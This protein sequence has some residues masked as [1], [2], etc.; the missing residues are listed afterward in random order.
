MTQLSKEEIKKIVDQNYIEDVN[1]RSQKP[2][3]TGQS[4]VN[5]TL[6][7]HAYSAA[8]ATAY[9]D[10]YWSSYNTTYYKTEYNGT[11]CVDCA[12]FVSQAIYA[13]EGKNPPDT[14]GMGTGGNYYTDWYY[15]FNNP[16]GTQNGSGS[17]PWINVQGQMSFIRNNASQVGPYGVLTTFT[18]VT[19]GDPVYISQDST[20]DHEG[21]IITKGSSLSTTTIDAH[22]T[23]RHHYALSN[24]ATFTPE[25][26]HIQGWQN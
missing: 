6:T 7:T 15:V 25:Y 22:C 12:N 10:T 5:L 26:V 20:R 14:S 13:G 23:N 4:A 18:N 11:T 24:W 2:S 19:A 16:P 3:T 1:Q 8:K 17:Y 21:I 9:A